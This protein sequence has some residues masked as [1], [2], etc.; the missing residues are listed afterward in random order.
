MVPEFEG[1]EVAKEVALHYPVK[2]SAI[3]GLKLYFLKL[4]EGV[5]CNYACLKSAVPTTRERLMK[6]YDEG[7]EKFEKELGVEKLIK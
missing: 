6:L 5:C 4:F 2:L 1:T 3:N 7:T